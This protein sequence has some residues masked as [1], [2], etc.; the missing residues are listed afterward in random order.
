MEVV[1][2]TNGEPIHSPIAAKQTADQRAGFLAA[3][4]PIG[5]HLTIIEDSG[6]PDLVQSQFLVG[7]NLSFLVIEVGCG[8]IEFEIPRLVWDYSL[9]S[10]K[11]EELLILWTLHLWL[12]GTQMVFLILS[13]WKMNQMGLLWRRN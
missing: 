7:S 13:L 1:F 8:L 6:C 10:D 4:P 5:V 11:G 9:S 3:N 12:C 2:R